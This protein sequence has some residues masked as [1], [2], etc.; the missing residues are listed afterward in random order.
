MTAVHH[1]SMPMD[2]YQGARDYLSKTMLGKF[3]DCPARFKHYYIDGGEQESTPSLRLGCA[4]HTMA[5]EP[6]KW[7]TDYHVLPQTYKNE[8]GEVK[9]WIHNESWKHVQEEILRAGNKTVLKQ[10]EIAQIEGMANALVR[11]PL[12]MS[13]LK[14]PGYV[15]SSIFWE[16]SQG[17]KLKCRPD[18]MRNDGLIV[19]LK[20][21]K[22]VK[23]DVFFSDAYKFNYHLSAALTWEGYEALH[24]KEA[25]NYIFLCI[26]PEPPYLISC[27]E[28]VK[29]MSDLSGVSYLDYG[30]REL[31]RLLAEIKDCREKNVWPSY[32]D[33]IIPMRVPGWELKKLTTGEADV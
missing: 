27:F 8:K 21:A 13:L 12:A 33:K 31:T 19:D 29:P 10:D 32:T 4:V 3:A 26:E 11:N 9:K 16:N 7:R 30:R 5:L 2:E 6:D 23:P 20:T 14:A 28:S 17:Q 18:L 24:G 15:E 1:K 22:S 25:D